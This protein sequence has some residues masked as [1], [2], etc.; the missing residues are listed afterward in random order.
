MNGKKHFLFV[1][2][3]IKRE[4]DIFQ[5][6]FD[7][8]FGGKNDVVTISVPADM[9][10][11]ML[12]SIM[13]GDDFETDIVEIL[14]EKVPIARTI[15]EPYSRD[16]FAEIYYFFDFDEHSNNIYGTS[17]I[18]ALSEMLSVLNNETELGKLYISYP[19]IEAIRDYV[20]GSCETVSGNCFRNRNEFEAY[21]KDSSV[22]TNNNNI[23]QYDFT[24]WK[25]VISN[26]IY[27]SS[28]LFSINKLDR[29][30][31]VEIVQP[32]TIFAKEMEI[33]EETDNIFIISSLPEF[34]IDYSFNYWNAAIGKRKKPVLVKDCT[35]LRKLGE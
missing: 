2:E 20:S 29:E 11:Y 10:I 31:F 3:G 5:N 32:S 23:T 7:I 24:N 14:K 6:V 34:L 26:Y 15:L 33:Y 13:K 8:F 25:N 30:S 9:N 35:F 12:Y 4:M 1:V 27:R 22:N 18:D 21:K 19:M 16:S 28:C 17:N